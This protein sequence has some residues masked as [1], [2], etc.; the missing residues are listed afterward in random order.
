[1]N[2]ILRRTE[3]KHSLHDISTYRAGITQSTAHRQLKKFTDEALR[4]HNLTTMQWFI[5]GAIHD[6][7]RQGITIT[8]LSKIV[9]TNVPYITNTLNKL[10]IKGM[11]SRE[12]HPKDSRIRIVRL[13]PA[14]RPSFKAIENSLRKKMR[15]TLYATVTPEELRV[16]ITVLS[17]LSNDLSPADN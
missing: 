17:K 7:G 4:E 12:A 10:E 9:D 1:M 13:Q 16:Y 11:V 5:L 2:P 8:E 15:N 6:T 14:F 3:A